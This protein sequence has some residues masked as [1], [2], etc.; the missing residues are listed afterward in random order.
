[1]KNK[2]CWNFGF[3]QIFIDDDSIIL[4]GKYDFPTII[5]FA[6][7]AH[8]F[9]MIYATILL[10][11]ELPHCCLYSILS[12]TLIL[13]L[14]ICCLELQLKNTLWICICKD[15]CMVA[16]SQVWKSLDT[17]CCKTVKSCFQIKSGGDFSL[18]T[19]IFIEHVYKII[20]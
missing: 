10:V 16:S 15:M 7:T 9:W 8:A 5:W 11:N 3:V 6:S 2:L 4:Q 1:M 18:I 19:S 20:L 13:K 12:F 17:C 14:S